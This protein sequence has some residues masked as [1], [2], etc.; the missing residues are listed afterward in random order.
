[1]DR[2]HAVSRVAYWDVLMKA[3]AVMAL[4][5]LVGMGCATAPR[6][7]AE[8]PKRRATWA[9]DP[10][11]API[12]KK[13]FGDLLD[14][15]R[16]HTGA[17]ASLFL[18]LDAQEQTEDTDATISASQ[19]PLSRM[20]NLDRAALS[21]LAGPQPQQVRGKTSFYVRFNFAEATRN[22]RGALVLNPDDAATINQLALLRLEI[23]RHTAGWSPAPQ[24]LTVPDD[25]GT[26]TRQ[27][28]LDLA[29]RIVARGLSL[30]PN[31]ATLH[32]TSG[33]IEFE[34]HRYEEALLSFD[35]ARKL[36]PNFEQAHFNFAALAFELHAYGR[37]ID[38][39][40][41]ALRL[42]PKSYDARLGLAL[43]LYA[44]L[45]REA[46]RGG[47]REILTLL[48]EARMLAPARPE[49]YFNAALFVQDALARSELDPI[50]AVQ[51]LD[52]A[53][54]LFGSFLARANPEI[55]A[56][57]IRIARKRRAA[58][59]DT[60]RFVAGAGFEGEC[61]RSH[62]QDSVF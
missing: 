17:R 37:A 56:S 5:L 6:R 14:E 51:R 59:K 15:A 22:L 24:A 50:V 52:D 2:R 47:G 9:P 32:N 46:S 25:G 36:R 38:G 60:L 42:A 31:D 27:Q 20:R 44:L 1:M 54:C 16:R 12:T 40:S 10:T 19:E 3:L 11:R 21:T 30:S 34:S 26:V 4:T 45:G 7:T 41:A 28:G 53:Y 35:R 8:I 13:A 23:A 49:A 39:Y 55:H 33:L 48:R 18:A 62:P 43:A 57:A 61:R 58:V 29:E